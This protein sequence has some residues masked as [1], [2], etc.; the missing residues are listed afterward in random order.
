MVKVIIGHNR[1]SVRMHGL[2]SNSPLPPLLVITKTPSS[3]RPGHQL[4]IRGFFT[5]SVTTTTLQFSCVTSCVSCVVIVVAWTKHHVVIL[6][7]LRE[8]AYLRALS[9]QLRI[10]TRCVRIKLLK[11]RISCLW[12]CLYSCYQW[13]VALDGYD[14]LTSTSNI[15]ISLEYHQ[16]SW[17]CVLSL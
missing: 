11:N 5:Q 14:I 10:T 2:P 13:Y 1:S 4:N 12:D 7:I 3:R 16:I 9:S 15:A 17:Q 6:S 8:F